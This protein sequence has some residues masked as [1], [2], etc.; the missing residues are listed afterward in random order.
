MDDNQRK[1]YKELIQTKKNQGKSDE[2]IR[3][4]LKDMLALKSKPADVRDRSLSTNDKF[5][6]IGPD[7]FKAKIAARTKQLPEKSID[8]NKLRK[9]A[10]KVGKKG[11][12]A[13]P[14]IGP[15]VSA[16]SS[17]D[18]S[19][20]VPI[21]GEAESLG[22]REGSLEA[23]L[24]DGTITDEEREELRRRALEAFKSQE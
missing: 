19:A 18:V 5:T 2:E 21:L 11:L 8:Y 17:G 22:P 23:K 12:K 14:L 15:V 7:E 10:S 24:E 13:I 3:K 6:T 1:Y 9:L 16:F 20:A 4:F